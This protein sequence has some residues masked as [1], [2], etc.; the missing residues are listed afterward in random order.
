M[1]SVGLFACAQVNSH[2]VC[3]QA[4]DH[5]E[6]PHFLFL[7]VDCAHAQLN[8]HL[9]CLRPLAKYELHGANALLQNLVVATKTCMLKMARTFLTPQ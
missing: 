3:L 4:K 8:S 9:V 5:F 1:T 7:R 2:L 6:I